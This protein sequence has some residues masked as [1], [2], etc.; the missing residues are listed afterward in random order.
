M[1]MR[2]I[3][4]MELIGA[5]LAAPAFAGEIEIKVPTMVCDTCCGVIVKAIQS[6]EGVTAVK[7]DME[8]KVMLVTYN[9]KGSLRG[10]IEKAV[11][12]AGYQADNVKADS[13]AFANL[14]GCCK[15]K[16]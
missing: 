15:T 10:K 2:V 12:K 4:M 11:S 8:K 14:P 1:K 9:T 6:V 3:G 13:E 5:M 16:P 7:P